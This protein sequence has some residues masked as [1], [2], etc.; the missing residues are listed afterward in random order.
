MVAI[1]NNYSESEGAVAA[2]R[3]DLLIAI[4]RLARTSAAQGNKDLARQL[5]S[6]IIASPKAD[7]A[8]REEFELA[9]LRRT[10]QLD[11]EVSSKDTEIPVQDSADLA[12]LLR[13]I[14]ES[15]PNLE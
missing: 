13:Q 2:G 5:R 15:V 7:S 14:L 10:D 9:M 3:A 12:Q 8:S 11:H 6:M 1:V 4:E